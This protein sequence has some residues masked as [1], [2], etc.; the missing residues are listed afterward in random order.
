MVSHVF[1]DRQR[2]DICSPRAELADSD[3]GS[4]APHSLH[5]STDTLLLCLST[6][7]AC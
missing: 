7:S 3:Q 6:E 1:G 5:R 2:E 4:R